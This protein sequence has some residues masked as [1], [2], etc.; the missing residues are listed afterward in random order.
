M[1]A[2][3]MRQKALL[4]I[5]AGCAVL[6]LSLAACGPVKGD[7]DAATAAQPVKR[8]QVVRIPRQPPAGKDLP[9]GTEQRLAA[10]R[11]PT[12]ELKIAQADLD[13]V[14]RASGENTTYPASFVADGKT[15]EHVKIRARGAWSRSWPKK[16]YK[17]LFDPEQP[18]QGHH[19]LNLNSGWH[20]PAFVREVVA[21]RVY[22]ACGVPAS[23][24]QM[25][26]LNVNGRFYGLYVEVEQPDKEFLRRHHLGG[27]ELYKAVARS[28]YADE[29]D[30]RDGASFEGVYTKETKKNDGF[31][32]LI[33]FCHEL[34]RATNPAAFFSRSLEVDE[35]INY[36]AA[37]ALTQNWDTTCKN[38][39][40]AYNGGSS[41]KWCVIPWDLDRTFGDHWEFRFNEARLPLLLGTRHYPWSGD[42]NRLEDRF[43]SEPKLR[44]KFLERMS[45]LLTKEFTTAKWFPVLD[46]LEQ[47]IGPAAAVDR[48]RWPSQGGDLHTAIAGVK[49]FIEQRRAFLL[50]EIA[51]F[52]SPAH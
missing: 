39:Y 28:R 8:T 49:S 30:L 22:E 11:L 44:Q 50:R 26:R 41:A 3:S 40:L 13:S 7:Q 45:E 29:S 46:Q 16:S 12:Y 5:W 21:Y 17:I 48:M 42:W 9:P 32:E 14:N 19:A 33:R 43:L 25:V 34:A 35:Y 23:H 51:A 2:V 10:C 36:L 4:T 38:H 52:R 27:A 24:A 1:I 20:D 31:G 6:L 15:Y 47:D 37:T 18:F